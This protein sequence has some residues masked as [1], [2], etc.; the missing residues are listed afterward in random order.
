MHELLLVN[1]FH[2]LGNMSAANGLMLTADGTAEFKPDPVG[3]APY[4]GD[5]GR[6]VSEGRG[7]NVGH[8]RR[9]TG[10]ESLRQS[11]VCGN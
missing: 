5:P 7:K 4:K 11:I 2:V 3:S 8:E 1:S 10:P 6:G 9:Q